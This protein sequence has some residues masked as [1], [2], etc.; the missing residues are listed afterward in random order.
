[1]VGG[2]AAAEPLTAATLVNFYQ[3]ILKG[4]LTVGLSDEGV[5]PCFSFD[6]YCEISIQ[7]E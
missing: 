3:Y 6:G 1:M 4:I 5:K 2:T 7:G